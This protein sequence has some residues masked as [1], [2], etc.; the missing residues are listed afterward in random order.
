MIT[1]ADIE[2]ELSVAE[3]RQLSD[4]N[5][6]GAIDNVI[7]QDAIDDALAFVS[8]FIPIPINPTPYLKSIAVEIAV[9]ELRKLH[10]LHDR[11]VMK[12][13]EAKLVRMA[14]GS[15]PTTTDTSQKQNASAASFRHGRRRISFEGFSDGH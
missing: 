10:D 11:E 5:A 4:L 8:S 1:I 2:N 14:K 3:L 9:Y 6:T 12:E 13:L 7:V 15:I